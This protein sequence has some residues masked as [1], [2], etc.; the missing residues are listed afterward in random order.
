MPRES[1]I[2]PAYT[3]IGIHADHKQMNKFSSATDPGFLNLKGD[4]NRRTKDILNDRSLLNHH[5]SGLQSPDR[6]K[7]LQLRVV[8]SSND[9]GC[10]HLNNVGQVEL[11]VE[12][13]WSALLKTLKPSLVAADQARHHLNYLNGTSEWILRDPFYKCW[14]DPNN[15]PQGLCVKGSPGSGNSVLASTVIQ[16]LQSKATTTG[17]TRLVAYFYC[18]QDSKESDQVHAFLRTIVYQIALQHPGAADLIYQSLEV[19][20]FLKNPDL[21]SNLPPKA[22]WELLSS[23]LLPL[24][25]HEAPLLFLVIDGLDELEATQKQVLGKSLRSCQIHYP[26]I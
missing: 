22:L 16:D 3:S 19:N 24:L 1:A 14:Q 17:S 18:H 21:F 12:I 9:L 10:S 20:R 8:C 6:S 23:S 15:V 2:L 26:W 5:V 13:D 11:K 4:I 7:R 25:G